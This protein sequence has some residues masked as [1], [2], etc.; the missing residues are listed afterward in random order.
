MLQQTQVTTV[1]PY[2]ERFLQRF[3]DLRTLAQAPLDDVLALWSGMGYYARARNLH[4]TAVICLEQRGGAMPAS[5]QALSELPGIGESTAN[6]IISQAH[7]VPAT[8]LDGNVRRVLARHA[9]IDGWLDDRR[10]RVERFKG[11]LKEMRLRSEIDFATLSVA[12]R[13]LRDLIAT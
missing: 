6:A 9:A 11:I 8:V 4:R 7:D 10:V 5:A 1:I 13:E 12:A 2:F 3:P